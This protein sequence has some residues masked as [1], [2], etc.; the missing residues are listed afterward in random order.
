MTALLDVLTVASFGVSVLGAAKPTFDWIT[1][2]TIGKKLD[3]LS[4]DI[5]RLE[6]H[7]WRFPEPEVIDITKSHQ[8]TLGSAEMMR[9]LV[10]PIQKD[11]GYDSLFSEPIK[12]PDILKHELQNNP[13]QILFRIQPLDS[14]AIDKDLFE[15]P[16]LTPVIFFKNGKNFIGW[17]K[18]GYL[19]SHLNIDYQAKAARE[20]TSN[21]AKKAADLIISETKRALDSPEK[22][23][24]PSRREVPV[25]TPNAEARSA[26]IGRDWKRGKIGYQR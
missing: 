18:I 9:E 10:S 1:G 14:G 22:E 25:P 24:L 4:R 26:W 15:D 5:S 19:R 7:V 2:N 16:T 3:G 23:I 13:E 20:I 21:I 8:Q 17:S 11:I 6:E 12:T